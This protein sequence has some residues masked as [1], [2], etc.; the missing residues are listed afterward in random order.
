MPQ[1][2]GDNFLEL[3]GGSLHYKSSN[4]H[5]FISTT[6]PRHGTTQRNGLANLNTSQTDFHIRKSGDYLTSTSAVLGKV[7][8]T[9][10][11]SAS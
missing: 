3:Q 2:S 7:S 1:V 11:S 10:S 6:A 8:R 9:V 5:I 4:S